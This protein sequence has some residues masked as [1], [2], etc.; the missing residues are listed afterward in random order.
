MK[1]K[2]QRYDKGKCPYCKKGNHTKK[3]CMK[4]TID[5][6]TKLLEHQNIYLPK[7][8]RKDDSGE[9]TKD[10]DERCRALEASCSKSH[11]FL[12]YSGASNH[13]V[14]SRESFSSLQLVDGL[15]IHIGDDTQIQAEGKGAIKLKHGVLKNVLYVPSLDAN[16][17]FVYHMAHIVPPKRVTIWS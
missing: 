11:A 9:K 14:A 10:H 13:M 5:Q 2:H 8:A 12:I 4:K 15:S 7:G 6:V 16:L 1:D 3:Y 17:F